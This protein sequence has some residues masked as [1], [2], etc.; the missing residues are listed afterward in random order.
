MLDS[1]SM[2]EATQ[3]L[4]EQL[5]TAM[6]SFPSDADLPP[7]EQISSVV[8]MGMGGSGI[9][10]DVLAA[11]AGDCPVPIVVS[12]GYDQPSFVGPGTLVIA[13]SFSGNTEETISAVSQAARAG[14]RLVALS[15]G[16]ELAD[17]V[18]RHGGQVIG[19]DPAI[20]M[21]RAAIGALSVPLLLLLERAGL[22]TGA[23]EQISGAI[24]Q[25]TVRRDRLTAD[26]RRVRSIARRIGRT[27]PIVYGAGPV[28]GVAAARWKCQFNENPKVPAFAN[29]IPEL[30]HNEICGWGQH[31]DV[32]RQV[33]TLV[34][35]RH[36]FEHPNE[37]RRFELVSEFSDEVVADVIEVR[38]EGEGRLA[39]LLDLVLVGDL[40]TLQ[41]AFDAGVDPGP[42]PVLDDIKARLAQ[43]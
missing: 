13:V 16:G 9:A 29:S 14:A 8:V 23:S 31:G 17:V 15:N 18:A 42:V 12:K 30:T 2:L 24:E 43:R 39:Q 40:V 32:T 27:F 36:D 3:S 6:A 10:G 22:I 28:G 37:E 20:P 33:F 4:P 26:P 21:P 34:Q 25:L 19:V 11:T 35:L 5:A 7:A 41:M 1:L 38:A